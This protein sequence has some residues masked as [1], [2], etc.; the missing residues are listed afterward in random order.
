[1]ENVWIVTAD[2]RAKELKRDLS[3]MK[4]V[5]YYRIQFGHSHEE[6]PRDVSRLVG[7][8]PSKPVA[9]SLAELARCKPVSESA[10]P[11]AVA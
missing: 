8:R 11:A 4:A 1:M 5:Y 7:P 6:P 10:E 9:C 2:D 3:T